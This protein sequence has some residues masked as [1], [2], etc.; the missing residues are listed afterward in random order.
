MRA[1]DE[2]TNYDAIRENDEIEARIVMKVIAQEDLREGG[3]TEAEA[4]II[5]RWLKT[6]SSWLEA[7]QQEGNARVE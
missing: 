7:R 4:E 3:L 1:N 2:P 5:F 6:K